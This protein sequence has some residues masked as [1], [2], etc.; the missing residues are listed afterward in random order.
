MSERVREKDARSAYRCD[1]IDSVDNVLRL[2]I[3]HKV[4][5]SDAREA[6]TQDLALF[7]V[8]QCIL[9]V[10]GE[11][12]VDSQECLS[13]GTGASTSASSLNAE[14]VVQQRHDVVVM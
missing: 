4:R 6:R 3:R 10:L 11:L 2:G 7:V 14:H 12:V 13:E 9:N 5:K 1:P 8:E